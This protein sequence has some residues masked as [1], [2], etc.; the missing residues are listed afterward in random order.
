[1]SE[2]YLDLREVRGKTKM[3]TST[4]YQRMMAGTFPRPLKRGRRSLWLES[5]VQ[6]TVDAEIKTLPRM[7]Q[8]MG[9]REKSKKKPLDSA[10]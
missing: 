3:A 7:G 10:A 5:E 6:A 1:M 4:I 2:S 9:R 8:S